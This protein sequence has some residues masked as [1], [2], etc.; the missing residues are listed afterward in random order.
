VA[1]VV[2]LPTV[3]LTVFATTRPGCVSVPAVRVAAF[4]TTPAERVAVAAMLAVVALAALAL[5]TTAL[6]TGWVTLSTAGAAACS[7]DPEAAPTDAGK[8]ACPPAGPAC[9]T[10]DASPTAWVTAV[11]IVAVTG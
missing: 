11:V 9:P 3:R 5:A 10:A 6:L 4:V 8:D 2:S 7:S 1:V